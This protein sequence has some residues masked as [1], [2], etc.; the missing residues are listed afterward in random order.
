MA[1]LPGVLTI[2]AA[3]GFDGPVC[4]ELAS[5]GPADVDE[6]TMIER[7]VRWLRAN[8]PSQVDPGANDR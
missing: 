2:L 8:V 7:S 5:L 6:L 3:V 1:D 4:V